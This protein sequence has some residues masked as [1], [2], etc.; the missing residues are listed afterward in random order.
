VLAGPRA[1][2]A[3]GRDYDR[4]ARLRT[5]DARRDTP[6]WAI[7]VLS[8][9]S[10]ILVLLADLSPVPNKTLFEVLTNYCIFGGSLFYYTAVIGVFVLRIRQPGA[11]RPYRTWGYPA[12]PAIFVIFY[13]YLLATMLWG[14]ETRLQSL[15]GLG[16]IALG[17]PAYF[18]MSWRSK[19]HSPKS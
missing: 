11:E 8:G 12:V 5:I 2:F 17:V 15:S 7:A 16:L 1:L 9:W 13:T 14:S 6:A 3:L 19:G 18:A 10:I 4:L